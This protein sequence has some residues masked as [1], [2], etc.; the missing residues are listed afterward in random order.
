MNTFKNLQ[1]RAEIVADSANAK[2]SFT[3]DAS[4]YRL[5]FITRDGARSIFTCLTAKEARAALDS[6]AVLCREVER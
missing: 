4:G 1:E 3:K 2:H 6:M 5:D